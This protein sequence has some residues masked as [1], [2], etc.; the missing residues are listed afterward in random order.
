M[1]HD[2]CDTIASAG[3]RLVSATD[4][5]IYALAW[6][7]FGV[8]HSLLAG[9]RRNRGVLAVAGRF[10]RLAYNLFAIVHLGVVLA[11]GRWLAAG[12][13]GFALPIRS[14][15]QTSELQSLMRIPYAAFCCKNKRQT[16]H[17]EIE[18]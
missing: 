2:G 6:L 18:N 8:G 5:L 10:H 16:I 14:E 4:Q 15:E 1:G 7:S 3:R 13:A 9:A 17:E 11:I 12:G